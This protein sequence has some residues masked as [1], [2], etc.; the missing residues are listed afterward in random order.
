MIT[1]TV[2]AA[3]LGVVAVIV[4]SLT[5]T[6]LFA[7]VVPKVAAVAPVKLTPVMVTGVPPAMGPDAGVTRMLDGFPKYVNVLDELLT[8][9]AG[10]WM[11]M[12]TVPAAWAGAFAVIQRPALRSVNILVA[13]MPSKV[14]CVALLRPVPLKLTRVAPEIG[15][16]V[17][18]I[19]RK[20]PAELY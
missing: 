13:G 8:I 9:P 15:P 11:R 7:G 6:K 17:G 10:V 18:E 12:A 19:L 4:V 2:P 5:K 16:Y 20:D 1:L 3:L 14:T